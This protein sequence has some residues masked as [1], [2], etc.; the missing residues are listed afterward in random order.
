M[1]E[2]FTSTTPRGEDCYKYRY[3]T[4]NIINIVTL[5]LE[6]NNMKFTL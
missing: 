3:V 1:N 4:W 5:R 2:Y 6:K